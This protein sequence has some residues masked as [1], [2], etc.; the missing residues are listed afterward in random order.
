MRRTTVDG[1]VQQ[2]YF[3]TMEISILC[4]LTLSLYAEGRVL[5]AISYK[6]FKLIEKIT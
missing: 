5:N 2:V 1:V 3:V 6:V 4:M